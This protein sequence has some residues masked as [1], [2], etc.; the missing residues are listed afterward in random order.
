M[1]VSSTPSLPPRVLGLFLEIVQSEIGAETIQL[2]LAKGDISSEV[3]DPKLALA[4]SPAMAAEKYSAIQKAM[5]TFYGRGA[6]GTLIRIGRLMWSKLL[7]GA[8]LADKAQAGMV[9]AMPT[10]MRRK[11]ALDLLARFLRSEGGDISTHTLDLDLLLVD[12]LSP[13]TINVHENAPICFV[14]LGLI[15]EALY[16]A[17]GREHDVEERDCRAKSG[18]QC[19]FKVTVGAKS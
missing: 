8:S 18:S 11:A 10:N 15:Q 17:T 5:R 1:T 13:V 4:L 12:R 7:D 3:A 2:V 16:W 9:R 14:T 19:E 6:R